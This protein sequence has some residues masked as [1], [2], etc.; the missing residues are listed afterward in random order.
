[1]DFF[2]TS[3]R[4]ASS[5]PCRAVKNV[6]GC[7]HIGSTI[8]SPQIQHCVEF[9]LFIYERDYYTFEGPDLELHYH[10]RALLLLTVFLTHAMT[11]SSAP[12]T[13]I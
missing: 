11:F 4:R 10:Q 13:H 12:I 8:Q 5:P 3:V 2:F 7:M 1:M 9:I 6:C